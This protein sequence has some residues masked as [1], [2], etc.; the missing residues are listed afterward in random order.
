MLY[1]RISVKFMLMRIS[2]T[3]VDYVSPSCSASLDLL[4]MYIYIYICGCCPCMYIVAG[5]VYMAVARVHIR[6]R[7]I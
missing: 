6:W 3:M 7:C 4:P 2:G 1:M 5:S